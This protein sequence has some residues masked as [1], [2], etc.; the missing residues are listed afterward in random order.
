MTFLG[1]RIWFKGHSSQN[2]FFHQGHCPQFLTLTLSSPRSSF[3]SAVHSFLFQKYLF[4]GWP[5]SRLKEGLA[6]PGP[7]TVP[8]PQ[9]AVNQ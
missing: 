8:S 9:E 3:V 4:T 5:A 7:K 6:Y 2:A 1:V